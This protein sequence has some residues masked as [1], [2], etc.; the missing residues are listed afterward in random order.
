[1]HDEIIL[2][3]L[4]GHPLSPPDV[5]AA[6]LAT[7]QTNAYVHRVNWLFDCVILVLLAGLSVVL[8]NMSRADLVLLAIGISAAY[9]LIALAIVSRWL[10][11]LPGVLPLG[12]LW[13]LV[14]LAIASARRQR[15]QTPDST[16]IPPPFP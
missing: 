11:W 10:I 12:L 5:F 7:I 1:M 2:A 9:C 6:T 8:R 3:R 13:L 15:R 4:P 14:L 16:S